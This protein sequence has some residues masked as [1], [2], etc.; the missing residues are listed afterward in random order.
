L[1]ATPFID[2]ETG[3]NEGQR[4]P[5]PVP[6]LNVSPSNPDDSINWAQFEP[7]ASSPG[8]F[9]GN[10]LPYGED[11]NLS[12]QRQFGTATILTLSYVGSQGHMLLSTIE[13]NPSNP[14]QCLSLNQLSEVTNGVTCGPFSETGLFYPVSGGAVTV[15]HPFG[16]AFGGNG[17]FS[18][19]ANSSY[20]SL[21]ISLR[22]TIGPLEFLAGY[23]YSK[24]MDNSSD[25]GNGQG[26]NL[27]PVN[28]KLTRGLSAFD[29]SQNF[30]TSYNY[31]IPF[32]KL[33]RPNR[34]TS[35]WHISGITRFATGFPVYMLETDDQ[36]LLGT[37]QSGQGNDVD[38]PNYTPGNL[39]FTNP[40]K[41]VLPNAQYPHGL[42][43]YFN[44]A[45]F[46]QE[47]LGQIGTANRRFFHG[48]GWNNWDMSLI[49]DLRLT[50]S[51]TFEFRAE[52]FNTFNHTQFGGAQGNYNNST[53]GF[54]TSANP[55]RIGQVAIKF[56]F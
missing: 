35:G 5:V 52:F 38:T 32:E 46:S 26:D 23:T 45:L 53:F 9:P 33:W 50:E 25:D 3:H 39:N 55:P 42:N 2:R 7:I 22:H 15:R 8:F 44:N 47:N 48:P 54:V 51:K 31:Q 10:H 49:K 18:T 28:P 34:L 11:Y 17:W 36:S 13:A 12:L 30:V 29:V 56:N 21:Q 16:P 43:P 20:N 19:I 24:A 27:N 37:F 6:P 14:A 41:A 1:F 40:R 4:F